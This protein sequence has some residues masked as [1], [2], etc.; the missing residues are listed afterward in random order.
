M[1]VVK[2]VSALYPM[3]YSM[4]LPRVCEMFEE[5]VHEQDEQPWGQCTP[6]RNSCVKADAR[7][8]VI[9]GVHSNR[10]FAVDA[11]QQ[12]NIWDVVGSH[13]SPQ[14]TLT[15]AVECIFEV[16]VDS[17]ETLLQTFRFS[18]DPIQLCL[19]QIDTSFPSASILSWHYQILF[20]SDFC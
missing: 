13:D 7:T 14:C 11:F 19:V 16:D 6:L 10:G 18:G 3:A 15:H 9:I 5:G 17:K 8:L 12:I 20:F 1:K 2:L 4:C